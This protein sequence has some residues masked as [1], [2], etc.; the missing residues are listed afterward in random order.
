MTDTQAASA[1]SEGENFLLCVVPV[2][3]EPADLELSAVRDNMRFVAQIGPRVVQ[4]CIDLDDLKQRRDEIT[5][6]ESEGIQLEL[7]SG[8]ARVRVASSV[9]EQEGFPLVELPD[10]LK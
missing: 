7:D 2:E 3:G 6:I 5:A 4:M 8:T 10:R 1:V 9:W